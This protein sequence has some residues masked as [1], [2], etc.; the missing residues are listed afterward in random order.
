MSTNK[1][2]CSHPAAPLAPINCLDICRCISIKSPDRTVRVI[3]R[4]C[5]WVIEVNR[6][7]QNTDVEAGPGILVEGTGTILDPFVI[8]NTHVTDGLVDR[9]YVHNQAV[10]IS[11]WNVTHNLGKFPAVTIVDSA[12]T[13]VYG[14]ITHVD[15]NNTTISFSSGFS[16]KAYFN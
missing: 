7:K 4:G 12:G 13:Q 15:T 1:T 6:G 16:G 10:A 11:T 14:T 2:V 3:K 9:H 5:D 8:T